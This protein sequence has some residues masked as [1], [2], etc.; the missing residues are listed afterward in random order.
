MLRW[1]NDL[2]RFVDAKMVDMIS[3]QM[4]FIIFQCVMIGLSMARWW[5]AEMIQ[6]DWYMHKRLV[7]LLDV[8]GLDLCR[9]D[10][11]NCLT[12]PNTKSKKR[13]TWKHAYV[14]DGRWGGCKKVHGLREIRTR[15]FIRLGLKRVQIRK[16]CSQ[17]VRKIWAPIWAPKFVGP[18][19]ICA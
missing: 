6:G 18:Q 12:A 3:E 9:E 7:W 2:M 5:D 15:G 1:T 10:K 11:W 16:K 17:W 13:W 4:I 14:V 8:Q 19:K